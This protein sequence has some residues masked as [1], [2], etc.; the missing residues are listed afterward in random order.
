[1]TGGLALEGV[2]KFF[3]AVRVVDDFSFA[4]DANELLG[5]DFSIELPRDAIPQAHFGASD[6]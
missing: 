5:I 1:M 3:G 4:L 2:S 6:Q